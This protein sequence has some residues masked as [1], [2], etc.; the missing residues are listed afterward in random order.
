[1]HTEKINEICK[2]AEQRMK[3]I[4]IGCFE[5]MEKPIFMISDQ[6]PGVW[7]EH[8]YDSVMYAKLYPDET[9][10]MRNV[11]ELFISSQTEQGQLPAYIWNKARFPKGT[12]V[13]GYAQ[14][15]ECVSFGSVCLM[16]YDILEDKDFLKKCY[17]ATAKWV[18]WLKSNR[19]TRNNG[20]IEMFCGYD[21]G[22]DDSGRLEGIS[23]KGNYAVDGVCQ[24]AA[25]LPPDDGITPIIAVDMNCNFYGN[26]RSLAEMARLLD[27]RAE[28]EM[29]KEQAAAVKKR[30]F[31]V[32]FDKDDCFFYDAD[33]YLNKRKI[34]TCTIFHL[35][36]ERVLD[37]DADAEL[38]K[39][40]YTKHLKNPDEFW[41]LLPFPS[42]ANNDPATAG[43]GSSN[44]WGYYCQM[45]IYL[46][47]TLW[48]DFYGFKDDFDYICT[49]VLESWTDHYDTIKLAQ[50]LDPLTGVP[51]NSS[52]WYSSCMLFY[53]Y[54]KRRLGL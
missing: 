47:C 49:K 41:T 37:K 46:R 20:L 52:E 33:R 31:E 32:C 51:T 23:C 36:L 10:Y 19:M 1:M 11:M 6:Y 40:I 27:K 43:H 2:T 9:E 18:S 5:G 54:A 13:L 42:V 17:D 26:L 16:A 14:I 3:N 28:A 8:L 34:K 25:V 7:M 15:Q 38:I 48:M 24:N 50:E 35:F 4:H 39:E 12:D 22:H 44:C 45:L 53:V 21:T 30:F 29:W